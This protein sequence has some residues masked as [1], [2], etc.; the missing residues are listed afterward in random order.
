MAT[1]AIPKCIGGG[2]GGGGGK[3]LCCKYELTHLRQDLE[4]EPTV[5]LKSY[6]KM[7]VGPSTP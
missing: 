3:E 7:T 5:L 2:G 4:S 6:N 1:V